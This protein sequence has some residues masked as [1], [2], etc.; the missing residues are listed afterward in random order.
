M[1]ITY[2]PFNNILKSK[3]VLTVFPHLTQLT[4]CRSAPDLQGVIILS[5]VIYSVKYITLQMCNLD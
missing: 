4:N 2:K 1:N 3:G 5:I